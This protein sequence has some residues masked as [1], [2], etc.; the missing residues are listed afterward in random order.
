MGAYDNTT[1]VTDNVTDN[2]ALYHNELK[3]AIDHVMSAANYAAYA[4]TQSITADKTL[5]DADFPIQTLTPDAARNVIL[6][7]VASTNHGYIISN[8]S[9]SFILTIKN[10]G[11]S[12]I[13]ALAVSSTTLLTSNGTTWRAISGG[14]AGGVATIVAGT[15]ISVDA[16]DPANPIVAATGSGGG[17]VLEVQVF[18]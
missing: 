7:A 14:G 10:A 2:L 6:P 12:T 11:G 1:T 18:S 3:T 9:A 5:T 16:T 15:G 8:G 4:N 17:S 13:T